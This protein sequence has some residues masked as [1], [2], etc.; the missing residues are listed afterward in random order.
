MYEAG[1]IGVRRV[2]AMGE[3]FDR[4]TMRA[5]AK[6][7]LAL[8]VGAPVDAPGEQT[9][10]YHPICSY[11]HGIDLHDTI[12]IERVQHRGAT[13]FD[14]AWSK[15]DG[16]TQPV[17]WLQEQDLV[18]KAYKAL[19][20]RTDREMLCSIRVRKSIPAG[21]GLGGGSSDAASVLMGLNEL[22]GLGFGR[23][24]LAAI[25]MSIGSDIAYFIDPDHT[26]A[27]P[28]LVSGFGDSIERV[29]TPHAGTEI[30]L[31]LPTFGCATGAVY[32]AF[33]ALCE[34][35]QPDEVRVRALIDSAALDRTKIFNDLYPAACATS[36]HLD[37]LRRGF[38]ERLG[39]A[40][41]MSGSGST[42][43]VLGRINE[44][45][46]HEVSPECRVVPTRLL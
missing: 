10:G 7:N 13:K 12:E 39:R 25:S 20:N 34:Q 19:H 42:L 18:V 15:G 14:I 28:A 32:R 45:H 31:I 36:G 16:L 37:R 8:A 41:H 43:F 40:V 46:V 33:D 26:P 44:A 35:D 21:G 9:H 30:T 5:Y 23:E 11:M 22:F 6:L 3:E 27:R 24:E 4:I 17:E 2:F 38:E 29:R 1:G